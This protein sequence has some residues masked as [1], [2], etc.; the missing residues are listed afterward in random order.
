M[1]VPPERQQSVG[2]LLL[3]LATAYSSATEVSNVK[4][5]MPTCLGI[6]DVVGLVSPPLPRC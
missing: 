5:P 2:L 6:Q 4:G 1:C 3:L